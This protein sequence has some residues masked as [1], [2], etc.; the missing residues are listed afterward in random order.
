MKIISPMTFLTLFLGVSI[1][2]FSKD[3]DGNWIE[4]YLDTNNGSEISRFTNYDNNSRWYYNLR[5]QGKSDIGK[6]FDDHSNGLEASLRLR[7][8]TMFTDDLGFT[9]DFWLKAKETYA[10]VNGETTN[11]YDD[12]DEDAAW[13]NLIFGL[14]SNTLGSL[15]YAKHTA[16]WAGLVA[17]IGNYGV[18]NIQADAGGK[19]AGK[20]IYKNYFDNNL[21]VHASFDYNSK[22]YG[23]DLGYQTANIYPFRPDTYGIYLSAYNGQPFLNMGYNNTI[24][25]NADISSNIKSDTGLDRH[26]DNLYTYSISGYKQFGFKGRIS[27]VIAYS[28]REN[29]ETEEDVRQRGYTTGGLGLSVSSTYLHIPDGFKGWAPLVTASHDEFTDKFTP[30]MQYWFEPS[31]RV[32]VG[33][34][35]TSHG[36]NST[37]AEFQIDI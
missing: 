21:F 2:S 34:D 27:T 4:N 1:N 7:G 14:E 36:E 15:V 19:N 35:L 18:Y 17:D 28:D 12:L 26:S 22:I 6:T 8:K 37:H 16:T 5:F 25:G 9:G 20:I 10:V 32:T 11:E 13:E 29:S 33:Y 30:Q 23:L 24:I 31:I 3:N